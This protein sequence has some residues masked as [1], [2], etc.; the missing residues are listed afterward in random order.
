MTN[1]IV[2]F[3]F[4]QHDVRVFET[5]GDPWFVAKDV[6]DALG[7]ADTSQAVRNHCD[8]A[9]SLKDMDP[10]FQ[11]VQQ[12]QWFSELDP[13]AKLIP[14]SDVYA[15]ILGS[16][17]ESAKRFKRW[18]V[19]DVLP[20]IRKTGAYQPPQTPGEALVAMAQNFLHHERQIA[21]LQLQQTET[22]AQVKALVDGEDYWTVVGYGNLIG[23]RL[24]SKRAQRLGTIAS[25]ICREKGW[26][27]AEATHP[28]WGRV[29]SYPR[30]AVAMAFDAEVA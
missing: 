3:K 23:E 7:Y 14:E 19:K 18:V 26:H 6:A 29:G 21:A 9:K 28:I 13:K 24:D 20:S 10:S 1:Q 12:N 11:R 27:K 30:Q 22:A 17:L 15:L 16:K 8:D 4:D 2:A 5:D 25:R